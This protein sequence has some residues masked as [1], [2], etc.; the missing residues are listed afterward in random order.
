MPKGVEHNAAFI[1]SAP[2][3]PV[4]HSLMPK[5]VEHSLEDQLL[6]NRITVIHSL[7]PKG[8]EHAE[9]KLIEAMEASD[10]FVDAE[11]R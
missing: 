9:A 2:M 10:P 11:R 8:V 3:H 6:Q 1:S 7:M 5:G 4:I